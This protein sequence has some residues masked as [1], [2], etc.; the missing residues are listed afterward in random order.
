[1]MGVSGNESLINREPVLYNRAIR[2]VPVLSGNAIRHKMIRHPGAYHLIKTCGLVGKLTLDQANY[3]FNGGSLTESSTSDNLAKIA[4]MQELLPLIRL[5][6]GSLRNQVISGSLIAKRGMLVCEENRS[7]IERELPE[8]LLKEL[9]EQRLRSCEDY[10][11]RFQYTRMDAVKLG[12]IAPVEND[13]REKSNQMIYAGQ[14]I[15]VGAVFYYGFILQNVSR[16]EVGATLNALY[17]WNKT[18]STIGGMSRIGHGTLETSLTMEKGE[19]FFG[20][21]LNHA[22]LIIEYQKHC[23]EN[24]DKIVDWLNNA[25]PRKEKIVKEKKGAKPKKAS[26]ELLDDFEQGLVVDGDGRIL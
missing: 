19:D 9:P 17:E 3:L 18:D 25:F 24:R 6:G 11:S 23:E 12:V 7:L 2:Y 10:I 16:L 21:E 15:I 20:D 26:V 1:M 13:D 22:S 5:L 8:Y 14:N 4:E